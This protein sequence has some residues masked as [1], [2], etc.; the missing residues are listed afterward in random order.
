MTTIETNGLST[1]SPAVE[2][3]HTY[4]IDAGVLGTTGC[5]KN[6]ELTGHLVCPDCRADALKE[7]ADALKE[8]ERINE[9]NQELVGAFLDAEMLKFIGWIRRQPLSDLGGDPGNLLTR[10]MRD[11]ADQRKSLEEK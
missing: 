5:G 3:R 7:R 8:Q 11:T 9:L 10:Y 6:T 2:Y 4:S 1:G